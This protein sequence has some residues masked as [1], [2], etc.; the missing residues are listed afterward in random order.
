M[1]KTGPDPFVIAIPCVSIRI[2]AG[3]ALL[4]KVVCSEGK[5]GRVMAH[6]KGFR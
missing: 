4:R 5:M 6:P 3:A 2:I 1:L